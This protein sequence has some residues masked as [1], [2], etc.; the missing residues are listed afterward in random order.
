[1]VH[2]SG[3]AGYV[4]AI[5]GWNVLDNNDDPY[6][7]VGYDHGTGEALDMAGAADNLDEEVGACPDC[8]I[9]PVRVG[10]SFITTGN[11]F[12]E[13]VLF[14][15]DSGATVVS[16]AL[17]ALDDTETDEQAVAYAESRGVPVVG[18]AAD[19]ESEHQN[20]PS[21]LGHII[22]VNSTTSETSW[23]P[24]SYLY[25]NGCTNYG[26]EISVTVPSTSCSSE[27]TGKAAG[28]IGLLESAAADAVTA[29]RI[30]DY[31]GLTNAL[32][33]P[34]PLSANEVMQLVTMSA[35]DVDFATAAP[36]ADPPAPAHNYKVSAPS[37]PLATTS[38]YPTTRGYDEYT[39][40]GRLDAARMVGWVAGGRI[41]P[42]AEIDAP[43]QFATFAPQ[44]TLEVSGTVGAVRSP[45]YRYQVDVGIGAAPADGTWHLVRQGEGHGSFQGV[46]GK[47]P[48]AALAG[49]FPGGAAALTGGAVTASGSP[50]PDRFTF[51]IR[52]EVEDESGLVGMAQSPEFLHSD[53]QLVLSD[54]FDSSITAPPRLAPLGPH[55]EDVLL[56][57]EAGGTIDAL[58]PGGAEL[59]G[60]PVHTDFMPA[61][62]GEAAYTSGAI[63]ARPREELIGGVAV[64]DLA[65]AAGA[66]LDVV[67]TGTLGH[68]YAWNASGQLLAGWPVHSDPAFSEQAARNAQN[69]LLPGLLAAPALGDLSGNGRLDVVAASMDRHVYAWGPSGAALPGWPVLVVDPA[70]VQSVNPVTNEVTFLASADALIGSELVDTPDIASLSGKGLPQVIVGSDEEYGGAPY[71]N[72]GQLGSILGLAGVTTANSRVYA[73]WADGSRH[74]VPPGG[75]TPPGMPDPGAFVKGW[76]AQIAQVEAGLLPTIGDGVTG[77][78]ALADLSGDGSLEVVAS[79]T[80]GPVYVL[81]PDGSSFLGYGSDGLPNVAGYQQA[82]SSILDWTLPGL[83]SP[84]VAPIGAHTSAAS[85]I[86]PGA[87]LGRLLD[88]EAP[89]D[90]TPHENQIDAWSATTG[91]LDTGF[92]AQMNDLQFFDQALV[93]DVNGAQ[94]GGYVVEG[95]G[96]Y[97]LRAYGPTGAEAPSF[98]KFTGGWMTYGPAYGP[99]GGL[100]TQVL[101]GGTRSGLLLVW[102]TP[103]PACASS[104]PWP[105][106]HHD[107]WNTGDLSET[108]AAAARCSGG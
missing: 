6:D 49:L 105:Q 99:W 8:M 92:P 41:P 83:G 46:L 38:M 2:R 90:Q 63:T 84:S 71:A 16:E 100:S 31:P 47:I 73:I 58:L 82:G 50:D 65:D 91:A 36:G 70:E 1:V 107:L 78:P 85:I 81:S 43:L 108:G 25:L 75:P 88:E 61:H 29:G 20:L 19:E 18:S 95:S 32:G 87:S 106:V 80:V 74:P 23:N 51:T 67:A 10:T 62:L 5:A 27:A 22:V 68:V 54:Q 15:V 26:A 93:A 59:P 56:V 37:V 44:G 11:E 39:G 69:R 57:T 40:W 9:L 102:S 79:S 21:S 35:D 7:D 103:T 13:G 24:P 28:T 94:A 64:G 53:A 55:G 66:A 12:A 48:L 89:G 76:P 86:D 33:R 4:D 14:A 77:S 45:S 42:V 52:V 97:D 3:P 60:W 101:A 96:L 30:S 17:G 104:G 34:V 98:P 72:L